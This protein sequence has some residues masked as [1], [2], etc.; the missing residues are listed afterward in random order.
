MA[1]IGEWG[2]EEGRGVGTWENRGQEVG[3]ERVG[4][5]SPKEVGTF[6]KH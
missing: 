5:R 3:E 6:I 4:D 2:E 1:L